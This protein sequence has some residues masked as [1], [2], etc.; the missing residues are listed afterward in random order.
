LWAGR[1]VRER[2]HG[3]KR[4][5]NPTAGDLNLRFETFD[6]PDHTGQRLMTF[7]AEP[8]SPSARVTR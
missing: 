2:T 8:G 4:F 6:L 5:H 7:T 1:D 3:T